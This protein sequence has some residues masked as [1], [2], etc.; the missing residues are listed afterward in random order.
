MIP[1]VQQQKRT[2]LYFTCLEQG[3]KQR[4]AGL[5]EP[6]GNQSADAPSSRKRH[7]NVE[8]REEQRYLQRGPVET[9]V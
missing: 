2:G 6:V 4:A 1:P 8:R 9:V 5:R 7:G 3:A